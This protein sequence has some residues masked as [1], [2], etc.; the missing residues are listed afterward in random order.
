MPGHLQSRFLTLVA[1]EPLW[2]GSRLIS[3][4]IGVQM[5]NMQVIKTAFGYFWSLSFTLR[6]RQ[7][8]VEEWLDDGLGRDITL[9]SPGL[10]AAWEGFVS[11]VSGNVGSL[12]L[13]RG[14]LIETVANKIRCVYS[15]TDTS[16]TPPAVG[17]R[18]VT[19][20]YEDENSQDKYGI[21]ECILS[22]G[23]T[24]A[25]NAAQIAQTAL[26]E[27]AE[28]QSDEKDNLES[29]VSPS[30]TVDCLGYVH[31]LKAYT[32][33]S[34]TTGLQNA[35]AK[36]QAI[37]AADP[38]G[39]FSTSYAGLD[40]NTTQ[41]R[42]YEKKNRTAWNLVKGIAALGDAGFDRWLF[43][44][45]GERQGFYYELPSDLKYQRALTDPRQDVETYGSGVRVSPWNVMPGEWVFYTDLLI[46]RTQSVA[47]TRRQDP[48]FLMIEQ[49][50]YNVPWA[51]TMDGS[52]VGRLDQL[53]AQ[54]GL[55]GTGG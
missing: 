21:I 32:Y 10:A 55:G 53:L 4:D 43:G 16:V 11:K 14:P 31:W 40:T 2:A 34:A 5:D 8:Q 6:G 45:R 30:V 24:S 25:A 50:T 12:S 38:N 13:T 3:D 26:A 41:V 36:L 1:R 15:T 51:L 7:S 44:V 19:D 29:S 28:P 48:R 18:D 23:G 42:A 20:W 27:M 49:A 22:V 17:S 35:S 52:R 37:L 33:A 54:L 47:A 9:F 39:I 46:G